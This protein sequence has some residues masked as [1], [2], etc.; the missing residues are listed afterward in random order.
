MC[1]T[2]IWPL[3]VLRQT[4]S[5]LQ[6]PLKSELGTHTCVERVT[7]I[8]CMVRFPAPS[9]ASTVI[10][11]TPADRV[12]KRLQLATSLP[13]APPPAAATPLTMTLVMP[14]PPLPLSV[15]SPATKTLATGR[16]CSAT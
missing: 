8:C 1:Q 12:I 15:A 14:R 2:P 9:V 11:L 4:R 16:L 13:D 3:V 5:D 7:L 10:V 6:S